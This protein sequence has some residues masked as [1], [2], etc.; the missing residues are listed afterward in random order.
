MAHVED[1]ADLWRP[2]LAGRI[3]MFDS[4]RE[5]ID[6]QVPGG[7]NAVYHVREYHMDISR[8]TGSTIRQHFYY[9]KIFSMDCWRMSNVAAVVPSLELAC[10]LIY[11]IVLKK[12]N[13][14]EL[15]IL[16]YAQ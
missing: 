6:L 16:R 14:K 4:P 7:M 8:K 11:E 1:W 2:D 12:R 5:N 9:L 15:E 13:N 10:G 3:S